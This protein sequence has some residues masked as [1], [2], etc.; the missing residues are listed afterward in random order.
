MNHSFYVVLMALFLPTSFTLAR[1]ELSVET[2]LGQ[3]DVIHPDDRA[4][5]SKLSPTQLTLQTRASSPHIYFFV[6]Y[7]V[8]PRDVQY[9]S[10]ASDVP[11]FQTFHVAGVEGP[12]FIAI[13]QD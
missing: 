8:S 7:S 10:Q 9:E 5:P 12:R 3:S 11:G 13:Y 2:L 1:G 4:T 6:R